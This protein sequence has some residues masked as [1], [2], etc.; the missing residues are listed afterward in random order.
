LAVPISR[1]ETK[2]LLRVYPAAS[3]NEVLGFTGEVLRVKVAAP[4]VRGK[5]N[6]EL[7]TFLS[8]VL[9]I[10]PR[11]LTI[12]QGHTSKN[13]VIAVAGLSQEEIMKRLLPGRL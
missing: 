2:I 7:L 13:K 8:Q 12:I 5:A 11:A 1:R 3:K 10:S 4:P 9:S 6:K